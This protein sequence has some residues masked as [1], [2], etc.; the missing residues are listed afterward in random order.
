LEYFVVF[1]YIFP[2]FGILHQEK[3][4]KPDLIFKRVCQTAERTP[5]MRREKKSL[6]NSK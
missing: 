2:S 6:K 3:S 5:E 1:W 4:G